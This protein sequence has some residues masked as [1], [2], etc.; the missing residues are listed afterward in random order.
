[1]LSHLRHHRKLTPA[2]R[3]RS[4]EELYDEVLDTAFFYNHMVKL[5]SLTAAE[6]AEAGALDL[7]AMLKV[8]EFTPERLARAKA[9]VE[10]L[11][12]LGLQD[13]LED[14]CAELTARFGSAL[15]RRQK[16]R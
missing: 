5:F 10:Q 9:N 3:D 16:V 11:D 6:V 12:V 14:F 8:I 2:A 1:V 4:L 7:W 13:H 15:L